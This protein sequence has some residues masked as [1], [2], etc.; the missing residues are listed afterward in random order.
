MA[1][2][3]V[4]FPGAMRTGP[5]IDADD[6]GAQ[7][8]P[9]DDE[10][11]GGVFGIEYRDAKGG[12]S[13]RDIVVRAVGWKSAKLQVGAHCLLRDAYRAFLAQNIMTLAHGRTG[14]IIPDPV[15][16]FGAMAS[17][18]GDNV[19]SAPRKEQ[20]ARPARLSITK[21]RKELRET[22]RPAAVL[23][24]AM[25]KADQHL[26]P[27]E[28]G[29]IADLVFEGARKT[30]TI[31]QTEMLADMVQE[32]T[33]LEPSASMITR[34]LNQT[35]DRGA[36]PS[37]LPQWLSRMARADGQ[38]VGAENDTY[39]EILTTLRRLIAKRDAATA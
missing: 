5:E 20:F 22:V 36:F 18:P 9:D 24:M 15:A 17:E 2:R 26:A 10:I 28:V 27:E 3:T 31:Q 21:M 1:R 39:R 14:E 12:I 38:V 6:Q 29:I 4:A 19:H 33:A 34:A 7:A 32:L 23:L 25:A 16:F 8:L 35:L 13:T 11:I 30:Y 37:D